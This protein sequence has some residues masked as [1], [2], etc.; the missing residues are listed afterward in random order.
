MAQQALDR[1]DIRPGLQQVGGERMAQP[2]DAARL[3]DGGALLRGMKDLRRGRIVDRVAP[4]LLVN[5]QILG[6][7]E[8]Q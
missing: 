7:Y 4:S 6:R 3:D 2:M 5:S 1:V 8:N